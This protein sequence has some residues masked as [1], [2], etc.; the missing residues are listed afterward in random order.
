MLNE[1]WYRDNVGNKMFWNTDPHPNGYFP[2][3]ELSFEIESR[4]SDRNRMQG[5]GTWPSFTYYGKMLIHIHGHLIANSPSLLNQYKMKLM[6]RLMPLTLGYRANRQTGIFG[7]QFTGFTESFQTAV[8]L[9]GTPSILNQAFYPSVVPIEITFKSFTPYM[10]G[11][12][13]GQRHW[14]A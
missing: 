11:T 7:C 2:I 13:T 6:E 4:S 10:T 3:E 9:E 1:V 8:T 12:Q 5:E 14:V